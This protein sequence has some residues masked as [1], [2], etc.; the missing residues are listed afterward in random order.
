MF[1]KSLNYFSLVNY[2]NLVNGIF[3]FDFFYVLLFLNCLEIVINMKICNEL[4][5]VR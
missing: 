5:L 2:W 1:L 4:V 3:I